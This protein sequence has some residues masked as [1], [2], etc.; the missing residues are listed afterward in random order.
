MESRLIARTGIISGLL[1]VLV[2]VVVLALVWR[3]RGTGETVGGIAGDANVSS[4]QYQKSVGNDSVTEETGAINA[5]GIDEPAQIRL[6][7]VSAGS[8]ISFVHDDGGGSE[9]YLVEAISAGLALFDYDCDGLTDIY[10]LCGSPLPPRT[11]QGEVNRLY[12]NMGNMR[13]VDVTAAAGVGDAGFGLGV[14]CGDYDHDGHAD[15]YVNNFGPNV[16]YR[17]A[18]DGTFANVTQVTGVDCGYEIGAGVIFL[19]A[20]GS[21]NLDLFVVNYSQSQIENHVKR[22][23]DGF[24]CYPG[25]LDFPSSKDVLYKNLGDGRFIDV[26][27]ESGIDRVAGNGMGAV[28]ADF[29]DDGDPDVFVANDMGPNFY[30]ENDGS[31]VFSEVGMLRGVAFDFRGAPNGNMGVDVGDFNND[32]KLDLYSTTYSNQVPNLFENLDR[33]VFQEMTGP[34]GAGVGMLPHV[35]WGT[36]FADFDND[37]LQDLIIGHG[38]LDQ[39]VHMWR[40]GTA[41]KVRNQLLRNLGGGRFADVTSVAG[42][43]LEVV[44]SSRGLALDDLDNDGRVDIVIQNSRSRPTMAHNRSAQNGH[45]LSLRLRGIESNRQAIGSRVR[46]TANGITQTQEV[47]CGRGY[48]SYWGERLHFGLGDAEE[49]ERIEIRWR[50][51]LVETLEQVAVDREVLL[52]EGRKGQTI[53]RYRAS[54]GNRGQSEASPSKSGH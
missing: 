38:A 45:W 19:D 10:L 21:G 26:S 34:A 36:G 7:D 29:D 11:G 32:G 6:I 48:Q 12:R 8:G 31:G 50:S 28:A 27:S 17:A 35:N 54:I 51:G 49:I 2:T 42:D 22:S 24:H 33:G 3:M 53:D 43:A 30:Y 16:M 13:F 25:P 23:I 44:E 9:K 37:G 20:A 5:I 47:V 15:I 40:I 18:G 41:F 39:N 46:V 52:V 14:A 4:E 1:F